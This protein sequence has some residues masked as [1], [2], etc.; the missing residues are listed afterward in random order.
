MTVVR[1]WRA[2]VPISRCVYLTSHSGL[3]MV[4]SSS[5]GNNAE[6]EGG[7][8]EHRDEH[9]FVTPLLRTRP[10]LP[11]EPLIANALCQY[12]PSPG[13]N[14][15]TCGVVQRTLRTII[16][17]FGRKDDASSSSF[18]RDGSGGTGTY[19]AGVTSRTYDMLSRH[20]CH[21]AAYVLMT[22]NLSESMM[23]PRLSSAVW[24]P[25][26]SKLM[27]TAAMADGKVVEGGGG[28]ELTMQV[29]SCGDDD[30]SEYLRDR[31]SSS[32]IRNHRPSST[33]GGCALLPG[34]F[35]LLP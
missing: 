8:E 13:T 14:A 3:R 24:I 35:H 32:S 11:L 9:G 28:T 29:L 20:G 26:E 16:E 5:S 23:R 31:S 22:G 17:R 19:G 21:V 30:L 18:P 2:F 15:S 1:S 10:L 6:E 33:G 7:G 34:P 27:T 4:S 25:M 12:D